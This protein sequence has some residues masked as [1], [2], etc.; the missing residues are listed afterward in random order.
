MKDGMKNNA[1]AARPRPNS[2]VG[3]IFIGVSLANPIVSMRSLI[4]I[5]VFVSGDR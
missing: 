1:A 5:F 2:R 4:F 3:W